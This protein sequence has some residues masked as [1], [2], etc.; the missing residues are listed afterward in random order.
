MTEIPFRR[1]S[2]PECIELLSVDLLDKHRSLVNELRLLAKSLKLEFGWHY[3]LDLTWIISR[4]GEIKGKRII[5]AGAGT[6]IL[7]WYLA[8]HG[9]EIISID[10]SSRYLLPIRF[11]KRFH[12]KGLRETDLSSD[13]DVLKNDLTKNSPSKSKSEVL[14]RVNHLRMDVSGYL[15]TE[16]ILHTVALH[17]KHP[18]S[19]RVIIYNQDMADL[20]DIQGNSI[21]AIASVSALEHNTPENLPVVV[22]ELLRVLKP[23]GTILAT[24]TAMKDIDTWHTPSSGW[25][26]S[27]ESLKRLFDLPEDTPDNYDTHDTLLQAVRNCGE[28]RD[29]LARFY[30]ESDQ[31]GMPWGKWDPQ[32]LPVGVWKVKQHG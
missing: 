22:K 13:F 31:N 32:Y 23:G 19:G 5:D 27:A 20:K 3:L 9:A 24:L 6:G 8:E 10:R 15:Q 26:Y 17:R 18:D 11:R 21:D 12:V 29:N 14:F 25:C 30:F 1:A 16:A 28:L 7:Q 2:N 4:L